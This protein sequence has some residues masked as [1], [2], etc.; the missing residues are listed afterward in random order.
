L[1]S[2][3]QTFHRHFAVQASVYRIPFASTQLTT[4]TVR[5]VLCAVSAGVDVVR[6]FAEA[7]VV[8]PQVV[9][10]PEQFVLLSPGVVIVYGLSLTWLLKP[11]ARTVSLFFAIHG[12]TKANSRTRKTVVSVRQNGERMGGAPLGGDFTTNLRFVLV[13]EALSRLEGSPAR[14]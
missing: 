10:V 14:R 3:K 1:R 13:F 6:Q 7:F 5:H 12:R 8:L 4:S 11:T 9:A 2:V